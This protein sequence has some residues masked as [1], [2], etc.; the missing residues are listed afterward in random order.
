MRI[1]TLQSLHAWSGI[2]T[3]TNAKH[4]SIFSLLYRSLQLSQELGVPAEG[5]SEKA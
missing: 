3:T 5:L 2:L 4:K 1:L